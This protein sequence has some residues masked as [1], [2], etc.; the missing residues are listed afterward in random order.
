MVKKIL[1]FFLTLIL[2]CPYLFLFKNINTFEF[3]LSELHT[4]FRNSF[5]QAALSA[6]ATMIFGFWA[7]MGLTTTKNLKHQRILEFVCLAPSFL[8]PLFFVTGI[9]QIIKPFPFGIFGIV[10]VHALMYIG[11]TS[12]FFYSMFQN[13]FK[14]LSELSYIEGASQS[15]FLKAVIRCI[16]F[17]LSMIFLFLFVQFFTSFSIP[18]LVGHQAITVETLIYQKIMTQGALGEAMAIS[19]ME[20]FLIAL[21]LFLYKSPKALAHGH[22]AEKIYLF[23][24]KTGWFLIVFPVGLFL[25]GALSGI[26]TGVSQWNNLVSTN[27]LPLLLRSV[28]LAIGVGFSVLFFLTLVVYTYRNKFL[29]KFLLSYIPLSTVL[30]GLGFLLVKLRLGFLEEDIKVIMALVILT[31]PTLYRY[32][33]RTQL[34]SLEGQIEVASLM[35]SNRFLTFKEIV[36]PQVFPTITFLAGLAAFWSIGDFAISQII[37]GKDATLSLYTQNLLGAYRLELANLLMILLL[38]LGLLVFITFREMK[39]VFSKKY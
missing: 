1:V 34:G 4:A 36:I 13:K 22:Q 28:G 19:L 37:F 39:Y 38:F 2:I 32:Q 18:M 6:I 21:I 23:D 20:S 31:V 10:I 14:S 17:E 29:D 15:Q 33:L 27:L 26:A 7:A 25:A 3:D 5:V 35:G 11:L 30:V 16:P 8:P 24:S 12:V 9:L